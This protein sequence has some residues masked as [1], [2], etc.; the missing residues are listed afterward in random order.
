MTSIKR[1][2]VEENQDAINSSIVGGHSSA[3][4]RLL[5]PLVYSGT[6]DTFKHRDVTPVIGREFEGLQVTDLLKLGDDMI[7]DLA[8][9]SLST[10]NAVA[11]L[12][13]DMDS[14]F[15]NAELSSFGAKM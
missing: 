8:I 5:K 7:R 2:H 14:Q 4:P 13:T 10:Q 11:E 3:L 6:L 12:Q 1:V 9:M 15:R